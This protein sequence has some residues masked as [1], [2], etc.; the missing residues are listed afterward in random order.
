VLKR[1][2]VLIVGEVHQIRKMVVYTNN[3]FD[4]GKHWEKSDGWERFGFY[5]KIEDLVN[6]IVEVGFSLEK[7][8]EPRLGEESYP[9][10]L[11]LKF[12][13]FS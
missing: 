6:P 12:K 5:R 8:L 3:Y 11:L 4:V 10:F 2:G 1:G 9:N 13:K 7:I